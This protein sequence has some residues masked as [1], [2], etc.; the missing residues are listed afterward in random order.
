M[1]KR[2]MLYDHRTYRIIRHVAFTSL[3][4]VADT[5]KALGSKLPTWRPWKARSI[6]SAPSLSTTDTSPRAVSR[7]RAS[8]R[9]GALPRATR[10][11]GGEQAWPMQRP[12]LSP[13][14]RAQMAAVA[15][16]V[17]WVGFAAG[18]AFDEPPARCHPAVD[19][20]PRSATSHG[21]RVAVRPCDSSWVPQAG[22]APPPGGDRAAKS[23]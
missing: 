22:T 19:G 8:L 21:H 2:G 3:K 17:C 5:A 14:V 23:G 12:T 7:R 13:A 4:D 16:P 10:H 20:A 1:G 6:R 15:R 9:R 11:G 18:S